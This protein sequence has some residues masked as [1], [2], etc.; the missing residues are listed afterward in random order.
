MM[1]K[2][3]RFLNGFMPIVLKI[4]YQ[5]PSISI[6]FTLCLTLHIP[7]LFFLVCI[8]SCSF[9][10]SNH[11]PGNKEYR[12]LVTS[13]QPYYKTCEK[14]EKTQVAQS[15]VDK[16]QSVFRGRF[17]ELDK[18]ADRWYVVPNIVA[19]RKVGQVS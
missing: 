14:T 10:C 15:I 1:I 6:H 7:A 4:S 18:E 17:L 13:K 12:D 8:S 5:Y 2:G 16:V 19:R 11:H 3:Q 9:L